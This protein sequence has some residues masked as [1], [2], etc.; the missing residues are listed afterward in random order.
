MA[1]VTEIARASVTEIARESGISKEKV[2]QVMD[3]VQ[4]L[5]N[6]HDEVRIGNLG[7]LKKK[8]IPARPA[9]KKMSFGKMIDAPATE[10]RVK[11]TFTHYKSAIIDPD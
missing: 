5:L 11:V 8:I 10:A 3:A 2:K 9:K 1:S 7:A 4:S 6:T